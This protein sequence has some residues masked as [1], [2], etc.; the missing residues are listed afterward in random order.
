ML[1]ALKNGP[2]IPA[3]QAY[4]KWG[5]NCQDYKVSSE[6]VTGRFASHP[7]VQVKLE[8]PKVPSSVKSIAEW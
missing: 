7:A 3:L 5:Q 1:Q 2:F 8:W 4:L 6:L